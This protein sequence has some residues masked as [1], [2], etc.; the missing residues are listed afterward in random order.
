[1]APA[2]TRPVSGERLAVPKA[3]A[4]ECMDSPGSRLPPDTCI[5]QG[6][7]CPVVSTSQAP[8]AEV[9]AVNGT[10][11]PWQR[12]CTLP[13][14]RELVNREAVPDS[15]VGVGAGGTGGCGDAPESL[16]P[17]PPPQAARPAARARAPAWRSGREK[18]GWIVEFMA[19]LL[20]VKN[21]KRI[22]QADGEAGH[23]TFPG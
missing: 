19:N 3:V 20:C 23:H 4:T 11:A 5:A 1:M 17:L 10:A 15:L 16:L 18:K 9:V 7:V 12:T 13:L 22:R 2:A 14:A 6:S 21:K 8:S